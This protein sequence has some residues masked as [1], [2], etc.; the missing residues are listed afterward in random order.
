MV[1]WYYKNPIGYYT[2][3]QKHKENDKVV[4]KKFK[5]TIL[6]GNCLWVEVN[7]YRKK[8][9]ETGKLENWVQFYSFLNDWQHVKNMVKDDSLKSIFHNADNFHFNIEELDAERLKVVKELAK[10]GKKITLFHKPHK[11]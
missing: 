8:N 2:L 6:H 11:D 7:Q 9:E 3:T 1:H 4:V 5:I 10:I